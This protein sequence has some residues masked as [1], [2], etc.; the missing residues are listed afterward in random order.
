MK[1]FLISLLALL[2]GLSSLCQ[3][4]KT[5]ELKIRA[6][7]I[8]SIAVKNQSISEGTSKTDNGLGNGGFTNYYTNNHGE[9]LKISTQQTMHYG[10]NK[11]SL[12]DTFRSVKHYYKID[13]PNT[14]YIITDYY[15]YHD[16]VF[17]IRIHAQYYDLTQS[18]FSDESE[19]FIANNFIDHLYIGDKQRK[20]YYQKLIANASD[21]YNTWK[22]QFEE[23]QLFLKKFKTGH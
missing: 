12:T 17:L 19:I 21:E 6:K 4:V 20:A 22:K 2:Y 8:D 7:F 16:S 18:F 1:R 13:T 3:Y 10:Y 15:Y 14:E 11:I 23:D 5:D 9:L